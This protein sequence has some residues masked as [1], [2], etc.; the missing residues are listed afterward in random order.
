LI[1]NRT[2]V[3]NIILAFASF[4]HIVDKKLINGIK[5]P[6]KSGSVNEKNYISVWF[7]LKEKRKKNIL[8]YMHANSDIY[9]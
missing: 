2:Q 4:S 8:T 1:L 7:V 3:I 6:N 9:R 5:K